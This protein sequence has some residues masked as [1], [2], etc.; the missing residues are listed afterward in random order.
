[1]YILI[2]AYHSTVLHARYNHIYINIMYATLS[3]SKC[4]V[5]VGDTILSIIDEWWFTID[6]GIF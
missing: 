1:M 3:S 2:V 6:C 4:K 5:W